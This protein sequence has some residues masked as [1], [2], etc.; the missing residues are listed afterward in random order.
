MEKDLCAAMALFDFI[1]NLAALLLWLSWCSRNLDPFVAQAPATI[2]GTL[3]R[4][5]PA[6]GRR[7]HLLASLVLVLAA[8]A[9][10]YHEV[11][12]AVGWTPKLDLGFVVLAFRSDL[13]GTAFL[14]SFLSF[15]RVW[16]V[17][18]FW[19]LTLVLINRGVAE[20][21]A[22]Q[23]LLRHHLGWV[24]SWP[25][26]V[27]IS[28]PVIGVAALW[29]AVHPLL[30]RAG[31]ITPSNGISQVVQQSLLLV[32]SLVFSLKYVL[33]VFLLL[34]LVASYV[35]L[36]VSPVWDFIGTTAR[37]IL[38]PLRLVPLRVAKVDLAPILGTLLVLALLHWAPNAIQSELGKR[39]LAIW[40]Q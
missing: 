35:Y 18:Y 6:A 39:H 29:L 33:P 14:Y 23:R 26:P 15:G 12:S 37:N 38:R 5:E 3:R 1:L 19:L 16:V 32:L 8:R 31:I 22:L 36:G 2:M 4:A 40:P 21:D 17:F 9:L 30:H 13:L 25:W 24:R 27:L 34:D 20:P 7:W 28:L 10:F 11:G